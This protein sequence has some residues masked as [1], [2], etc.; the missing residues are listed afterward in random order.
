MSGIFAENDFY[1][2][3]QKI[4]NKCVHEITFRS[5]DK[6]DKFVHKIISARKTQN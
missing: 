3:A 4:R 5:P 6:R 2:T 1:R